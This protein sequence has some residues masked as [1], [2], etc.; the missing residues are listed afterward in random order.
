MDSV[1]RNPLVRHS[2]RAHHSL[3]LAPAKKPD[4]LAANRA[5]AMHPLSRVVL[6]LPL[7]FPLYLPSKLHG[8]NN[9]P[10]CKSR[11]SSR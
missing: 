7:L 8:D 5:V 4:S 10:Q 11:Y 2:R 1:A 9:A 3:R 6:P